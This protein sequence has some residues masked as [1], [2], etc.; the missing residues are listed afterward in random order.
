MLTS[1]RKTGSR[2]ISGVHS[3]R[4]ESNVKGL[5]IELLLEIFGVVRDKHVFRFFIL[6]RVYVFRMVMFVEVLSAK[7]CKKARMFYHERV[8]IDDAVLTVVCDS[9]HPVISSTGFLRSRGG[10][11]K[12][13]ALVGARLKIS[14][15][16]SRAQPVHVGRCHARVFCVSGVSD[17]SFFSISGFWKCLE[18]RSLFLANRLSV[19]ALR[20]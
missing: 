7:S 12:S 10:E 3:L 6:I 9:R 5:R 16:W 17:G 19:Y 1:E 11:N 2:R 8:S 15:E 18:T 20:N 4:N 14:S 13:K